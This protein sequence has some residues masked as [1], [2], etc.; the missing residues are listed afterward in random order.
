MRR[1]SFRRLLSK[2]LP[3]DVNK[4]DLEWN[5]LVLKDIES[6]FYDYFF[7]ELY[8]RQTVS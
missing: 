7:L 1:N 2:L 5:E 3:R 6:V 8:G 4:N